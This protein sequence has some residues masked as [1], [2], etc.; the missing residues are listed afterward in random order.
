MK[1]QTSTP[2]L[3]TGLRYLTARCEQCGSRLSLPEWSEQVNDRSVRHLWTCDD[4][5][6]RFETTVYFAK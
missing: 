1:L 3:A 5:G 2:T 6:Y 4:C